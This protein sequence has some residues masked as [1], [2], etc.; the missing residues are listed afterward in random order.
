MNVMEHVAIS[1]M[2]RRKITKHEKINGNHALMS[3]SKYGEISQKEYGSTW[4][5]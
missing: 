1:T 3:F 4:K 5:Y 2:M